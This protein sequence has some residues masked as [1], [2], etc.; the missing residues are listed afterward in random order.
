MDT[1]RIKMSAQVN[2]L[3]AAMAKAQGMMKPAIK[4]SVNPHY[5]SRFTS[6]T[7]VW[8][9]ARL[10]MSSNGLSALQSVS[11]REKNI[12]VTTIILHSSGQWLEFEPL[13]L[14]LG[15]YDA[16]GVGSA[17][18]YAKRYALC[19]ALNIVTDDDDDGEKACEVPPKEPVKEAMIGPDEIKKLNE[20][21]EKVDNE[22]KEKFFRHIEQR[23]GKKNLSVVPMS[24][25]SVVFNAIDGY[26]KKAKE[27][28]KDA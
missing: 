10:P 19:A 21:L 14:P 25:F 12:V 9:S 28:V 8:E 16:Q 13:E 11:T 20:C 24:G 17:C 6:I 15:K 26:L 18:T 27:E 7:A 23:W 3:A 1:P 4:D 2:E 22:Y 5:K